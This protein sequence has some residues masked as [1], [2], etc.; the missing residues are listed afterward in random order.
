M[1]LQ[2]YYDLIK[3]QQKEQKDKDINDLKETAETGKK[4]VEEEYGKAIEETKENY[5]LELRKNE[6]QKEI[7]RRFIERKAAEL[8]LENSGFGN[9]G[10]IALQR[11][12]NNVKN[13]I[14]QQYRTAVD[15]LA[16]DMRK[17]LEEINNSLD[18][19]IDNIEKE[20]D[21]YAVNYAS[22]MYEAD[23]NAAKNAEN[24]YNSNFNNLKKLMLDNSITT[25]QKEKILKRENLNYSDFEYLADLGGIDLSVYINNRYVIPTNQTVEQMRNQALIDEFE[26][27]KRNHNSRIKP[28]LKK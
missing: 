5:Y 18:T 19:S 11:G 10:K 17:K 23:V 26:R 3:N 1:D 22:Q 14:S 6:L 7:N 27:N 12:Y 4:D 25:A 2:Q 9:N 20:Y 15:T 8:G 21:Q 13:E 16:A 24:E 28:I